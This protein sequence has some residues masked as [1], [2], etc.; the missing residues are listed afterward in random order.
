[1]HNARLNRAQAGNK[2]TRRNIN[3]VRYADDTTLM[4]ESKKEL[5]SL[6][7]KVKGKSEKASCLK[8]N[9]QKKKKI[10][11]S[12]SINSWQTGGEPME[13]VTDFFLGLQNHCAQ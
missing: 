7:V 10:M 5:K 12:G 6:L 11:V 8:L 13:K 9:V 1:M 4:A 2:T 3:N